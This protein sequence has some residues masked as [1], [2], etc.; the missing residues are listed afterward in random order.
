MKTALGCSVAFLVFLLVCSSIGYSGSMGNGAAQRQA[1]YGN[2]TPAPAQNAPAANPPGAAPAAGQNAA[3][4]PGLNAP[5]P[6]GA[7]M[8]N[9]IPLGAINATGGGHYQPLPVDHQWWRKRTLLVVAKGSRVQA[10]VDGQPGPVVN[11]IPVTQTLPQAKLGGCTNGSPQFSADQR[12]TSSTTTNTL[13][14]SAM[15]SPA[16]AIRLN[17]PPRR[18]GTILHTRYREH[19]ERTECTCIVRRR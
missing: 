12:G 15:M 10:Y 6:A 16:Y 8:L 9:A 5:V 19:P 13:S 17:C 7:I 1:A 18:W 14:W 3:I 4:I 11:G 2:A